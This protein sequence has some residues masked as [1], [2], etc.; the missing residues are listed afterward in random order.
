MVMGSIIVLAVVV[1]V[2][3]WSVNRSFY[4][5]LGLG[6]GVQYS[7]GTS[8]TLGFAKGPLWNLLFA[9]LINI[10]KHKQVHHEPCNAG[11]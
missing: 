7:H 5:R 8:F 9:I 4:R 10:S 6:W 1:G 3:N 2:G 11:N